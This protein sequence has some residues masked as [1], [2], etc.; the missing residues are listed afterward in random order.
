MHDTQWGCQTREFFRLM[1][2]VS[3]PDDAASYRAVVENDPAAALAE[4]ENA[5]TAD[6]VRA[7]P[8][9]EVFERLEQDPFT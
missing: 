7:T 1:A 2:T 4:T 6:S 8:I 3:A 9:A 5:T